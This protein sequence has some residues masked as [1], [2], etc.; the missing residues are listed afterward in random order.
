MKNNHVIFIR[1]CVLALGY[2]I[3]FYS[4]IVSSEISPAIAQ[5]ELCTG[6]VKFTKLDNSRQSEG[7]IVDGESL[8]TSDAEN[9][10]CR[11]TFQNG[12]VVHIGSATEIKFENNQHITL[13]QGQL[14]AYAMPSLDEHQP[15][16]LQINHGELA[17]SMGKIYAKV[18]KDERQLAVFNDLVSAIWH[19]NSGEKTLYPNNLINLSSTSIDI[20]QI[21]RNMEAEVTEQTSPETPAVKQAIQVFKK[22]DLV[23]ATRLFRQI[24]QAFPYNAAAAYHLGLFELKANKVSEAVEQW[25]KYVE[26]DPI[27]AKNSGVTK[28]LTLMNTQSIQDEVSQAIVNEKKLSQLP[29]EPNS[30]AVNPLINKGGEQYQPIGK[31]LTAFVITDLA[32]VPGLKVLEREKL[33]K[34][35]DEIK[36]SEK[37]GLT[38][39][40]ARVRADRMMRAEKLMIGDYLIESNKG[41]RQ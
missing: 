29:A 33:Q 35:I 41:G 30:I 28:Q 17:L 15:M 16:I 21:P 36:L 25:R 2:G 11:I 27:G 24:Q 9:S 1:V 20:T 4:P 6:N 39:D 7:I 10:R 37:D 32:K 8:Q 19:D 3:A 14:V 26:I 38:E 12:N 22:R 23:T 34:L 13:L 40:S 5:V 31:G 18:T